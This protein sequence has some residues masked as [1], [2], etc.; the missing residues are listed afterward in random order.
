[1]RVGRVCVMSIVTTLLLCSLAAGQSATRPAAAAIATPGE[2]ENEP[3]RHVG[4]PT[5]GPTSRES[6]NAARATSR[7]PAWMETGRVALALL[8]VLALIFLLRWI[9]KRLLPNAAGGRA[10]SVVRVLSRSAVSGRQQVLLVQVGRRVLVVADNGTQ[11]SPLS[12]ITDADEVA[13]LIGQLGGSA[14]PAAF[15]AALGA[16]KEEFDEKVEA[17]DDQPDQAVVQTR[18]E[19]DGLMEKVRVLARQLGRSA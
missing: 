13:N 12:E 16:A 7:M 10:G 5:T 1:M 9:G 3:I 6:A 18:G 17:N 4:V 8:T 19:I 11:M 14:N 2:Y 15:G